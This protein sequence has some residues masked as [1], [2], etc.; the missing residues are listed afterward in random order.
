MSKVI[1]TLFVFCSVAFSTHKPTDEKSTASVNQY[2]G[3]YIFTDSKPAAQYDYLG[4][5]EIKHSK[6]GPQYEPVRDEMIKQVKKKYPQADGAILHFAN[7]AIDK[8]DA[9]KFK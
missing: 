4:T 5:I 3:V 6:L 7:D 2:Q 1:L 8:A 9:I